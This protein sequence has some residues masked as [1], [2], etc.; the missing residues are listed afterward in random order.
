MPRLFSGSPWQQFRQRWE[1]CNACKLHEVRKHVVLCRGKLPADVLFI[2]EAPGNSEDV[3][4]QPFIGPAGKLLDEQVALAMHNVDRNL[5]LC[6][7]NLV[8]C[9]PKEHGKKLGEPSHECVVACKP[10]LVDFVVRLC[11]P[12]LL[13][14][15]GDLAEKELKDD[16]KCIERVKITHPA[17]ILRAEMVRQPLMYQ[18]TVVSLENFFHDL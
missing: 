15:V 2:G 4:G 5:R 12:R 10:R 16:F 3:I 14:M 18:R 8:C 6:F 7:T 1:D 17:A 13:V 11:Q 9:I